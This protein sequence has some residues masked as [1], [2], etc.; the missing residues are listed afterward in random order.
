MSYQTIQYDNDG[1]VAVLTFHRPETRNAINEVMIHELD[2]ILQ[3]IAADKKLRVLILTGDGKSFVAGGDISM[4]DKGLD[5]PYEFFL[6]H[7]ILTEIGKRLERLTIP[8]IAAINGN[9]RARGFGKQ[10][11]H[12]GTGQLGHV[13]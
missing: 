11:A 4:I 3:N 12:Q 6:L 5:H 2:D 7:D 9:L 1:Q 8:V 10:G 13:L